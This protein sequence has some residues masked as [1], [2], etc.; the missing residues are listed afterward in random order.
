[1]R[2]TTVTH[3]GDPQIRLYAGRQT[4]S[5]NSCSQ[6]GCPRDFTQKIG[7][8]SLN[9]I[10]AIETRALVCRMTCGEPPRWS[11]TTPSSNANSANWPSGEWT[12]DDQFQGLRASAF[13]TDY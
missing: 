6:F 9:G 2:E 3:Y 5:A 12:E 8:R 11:R 10:G 7:L 1:M 13:P 4:P